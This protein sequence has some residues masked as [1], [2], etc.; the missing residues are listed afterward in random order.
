MCKICTSFA[1]GQG[2][3]AFIERPGNI[4]DHPTE[5]FTN[6]LKTKRHKD[7][8]SNRTAYLEMCNCGTDVWKLA[9]EASLASTATKINCNRFVIKSF[10][11]IVHSMIIKNWV[12]T[13]NFNDVVDLISQCGS[14]EI[15]SHLIMAPK[16]VTYMSPEYISKYVTIMAEFVKKPLHSTMKN[17]EFTF[18]SDETQDITLIEQLV[19]YATFL[20]DTVVKEHFVGFIPVSKVVGMHLSA[21]NIMGA[22]ERFFKDLDIPLRNAKFACMDTTNVN[23]GE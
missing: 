14:K 15:S 17:N 16:N 18:Y 7:A 22:L 19:I 20:Q 3:R 9:R 13:H 10:F 2:D 5:R 6:H 21:V 23:S 1:T 8:L 11:G 4:G 12:Y